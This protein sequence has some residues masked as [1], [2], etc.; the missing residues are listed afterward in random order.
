MSRPEMDM[1]DATTRQ[2]WNAIE[3]PVGKIHHALTMGNFAR[4]DKLLQEAEYILENLGNNEFPFLDRPIADYL[5]PKTASQLE[6]LQ[7]VTNRDLIEAISQGL[8]N[9]SLG[10]DTRERLK[11]RAL[12]EAYQEIQRLEMR[13]D[14]ANP[15][16]A[17]DPSQSQD[18]IEAD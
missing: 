10:R 12:K 9:T 6:A 15:T 8:L 4:A 18:R 16:Q 5:P 2:R 13:A 17:E 11:D 3:I 1:E 7:V 14:E